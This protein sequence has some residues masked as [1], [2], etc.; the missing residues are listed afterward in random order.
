[1]IKFYTLSILLFGSLSLPMGAFNSSKVT[2]N[3]IPPTQTDSPG[4][5][6]SEADTSR[7]VDVDEVIVVAQPREQFR[8]RLQPVS[9]SM[10][11]A[12]DFE[13]LNIRDLRD[14]SLYTPSFVMPHYGSRYTSTMYVRG[15]GTRV[16]SPAVGMYVDGLPMV[17]KSQMNF[18]TYETSRVDILRGPQ[19]TLYGMNTEGGLIRLYS[20]SPMDYQ[21]T[22]VTLGMGS[23]MYRNVE[24]AHYSKPSDQFAF[25]IA[26]FYSGENG[27]FRNATTGNRA[28]NYNEAGGK[29]RL[30][31]Q[32][33]SRLNFDFIAD[34]QWVRQNAFPYGELDMETMKAASPNTNLDNNYRRQM[35]NTG[36]N[37]KYAGKGYDLYS[38]TSFQH[39]NDHMLMDIDYLPVNNMHLIQEQLQNG[40]TQEFVVKT[41]G[42]RRWR[43]SSGV[44]GSYTWLRTDGPVYFDQGFNDQLSQTIHDAAYYP[45]INA[46]ASRMEERMGKE[47]A[48]EW[49][50]NMVESQ[51][52]VH[53]N[54]EIDDVPGI[55]HTPQGN[56][57]LFHESNLDL[58]D[59]LTA[60][61]GLRF[62][63][64][65]VKIDYNTSGRAA[66]DM[67]VMGTNVKASAVS[68]LI[69]KESDTY[70]QFLPKVG[71]TYRVDDHGSNVYATLSK[72]YRAG[73]FNFQMFSDILQKEVDD[74][75][76]RSAR[77]DVDIVVEHDEK[78]YDNIRN[79]IAYK[80]EE[81][82]NYEFGTHLNLFDNR[83]HLDLSGYYMLIRNQQLSVMASDYGFGRMM[84][85]AGKS[86]SC[87]VELS[88]R[89]S[90][91]GGHL[92]WSA[93][94]GYTH[95]VFKEYN[96][97]IQTDEGI[98]QISYKDKRVPFVPEHTLGAS[99]DYR[100]D[101]RGA[102]HSLT[103][104]ANASLQGKTYWDEANSYG[105]DFYGLLGAHAKADFGMV[106]VNVWARNITNTNYNTFA[107]LNAST[108]SHFAQRGNPFQMGVDVSLHF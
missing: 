9:S 83:L 15:I 35:L 60:T 17:S 5:T 19:G 72:G 76:L 56:L 106:A 26:G 69:H 52:G 7:V 100:F 50:R 90:A 43:T 94:Y 48:M 37:V 29:L 82:W 30:I 99:A 88:L 46:M 75:R 78:A 42:N 10:F 6:E 87:G 84:V 108:G 93:S 81:S 107:L 25:S 77:Q 1:M 38:T 39:L 70:K 41:G 101:F 79:T 8:L 104:G 73:G 55:F 67:S 86:Y 22:D 65:H 20:K 95:A 97:S 98:K 47:G 54:M 45:M 13:A 103:I 4:E 23:R 16:N 74:P 66:I 3:N 96:D 28:D 64:T 62:D 27:F 18:H 71:L 80:P 32:P 59:R 89:G 102:M 31:F 85:N 14:L 44:F 61:L 24:A 105:Q 53:I 2:I 21:G 33:T 57:G 49:A 58:T 92:N 11:N 40:L 12:D 68:E 51:G 63:L 91:L 36:L 34:Y